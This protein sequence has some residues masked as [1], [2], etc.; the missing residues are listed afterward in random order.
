MISLVCLAG[1]IV[2]AV[3]A[4]N[5]LAY[6]YGFENTM[7]GGGAVTERNGENSP[8]AKITLTWDPVSGA[9]AYNLYWSSQKGVTKESGNRIQGVMPPYTYDKIENGRAYYFVVTAVRGDA[10]SS[11]SN[12]VSYPNEK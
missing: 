5:R 11:E 7:G 3:F 9:S 2:L 10:E 1:V 8:Q 6:F 4:Y 12:E